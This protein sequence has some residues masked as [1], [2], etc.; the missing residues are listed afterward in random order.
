MTG[1]K[2]IELAR[3]LLLAGNFAGARRESQ[4]CLTTP[5]D[6]KEK[7]AAH[8]ILA[9]CCRHE[10]NQKGML[11][12]AAEAVAAAPND[13]LAH[14]ALAECADEIGDKLRAIAELRRAIECAPDM[15]QAHRYLGA[16][17]ID[18]GDA[19]LGIDSLQ[20]AVALDAQ[21][22]ESW[23]NLGTALHHANRLAEADAAYRQALALKPDYPRAVCNVAV[24]QRDQGDA[25]QAEAT[26]R[27]FISRQPP[28]TV[29]R[30]A[31]T[32][33]ADLLRSRGELDEAAQLYLRA[34]KLAPDASS[35]EM[36][37]LGMVLTER[38]DPLQAKKAYGVALRQNPRYLRAALAMNLTLPV[39]YADASDV[40]RARAEYVNG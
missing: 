23:N 12:H 18:A 26:L 19:A 4:A 30:P 32:A 39:I 1:T 7:S 2:R 31:L 29:F 14:Y 11:A 28:E 27:S 34:A 22:A 24:L 10:G 15:V 38:G 6:T 3:Q 8:L 33:L 13:A 37:D 5:S 9:A 16:L 20:R 21:H 36:L 35:R 25:Q 17:L 40:V